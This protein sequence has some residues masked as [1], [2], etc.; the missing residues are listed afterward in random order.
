MDYRKQYQSKKCTAEHAAG[1]VFPRNC[2]FYGGLVG[3]PMSIDRALAARA[4]ELEGVTLITGTFPGMPAAVVSDPERKSFIYSNLH[5]SDG[6]RKLHDRG[7]CDF[8]PNMYQDRPWI[9]E[10]CIWPDIIMVRTAPMD[11]HGYFNFGAINSETWSVIKNA[12]TVIVEVNENMPYCY[13]GFRECVHISEVDHVVEG[14]NEPLPEAKSP[15]PAEADTRIA[16]HVIGQIRDGACIQLGIGTLPNEVGK[17][18]AESD[19]RD[20]GVHTEMLADSYLDMFRAGR[21]TGNRKTTDPGKMVYTFAYGSRAL[22]EFLD[23]NPACASFPVN[24]TNSADVISLNERTV[25][26][27]KA[28]AVDLYGQVSSES[29]GFRQISG[30]GGQW[31]F[32]FGA[33]RSREGC[34]FICLHSTH[35]GADG[36]MTSRIRPCLDPGSIVTVP[37]ASV[38]CVVTEFGIAGLRG[39]STWQRAEALINISHPD[40]RDELV[41]EAEKM[42]IWTRTNRIP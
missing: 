32:H 29:S 2:V 38:M 7:L 39:R 27:N 20:L 24:Y 15:P 25:S 17:M 4:H 10:H 30:T 41:R 36:K 26:I 18:I 13:G 21:I 19:L 23:H 9:F 37:R 3:A 35:T 11:E 12:R 16:A 6:D 8:I 1:R 34:G 5:F 42:N 22:Y 33:A 31:D 28:I 40:F 14:G